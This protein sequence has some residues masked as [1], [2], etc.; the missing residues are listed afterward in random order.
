MNMAVFPVYEQ[1]FTQLSYIMVVALN[2]LTI[3]ILLE[4]RDCNYHG[5][6]YGAR[7]NHLKLWR[8]AKIDAA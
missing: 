7:R 1:R 8:R 5:N 4:T 6:E 3:L 2:S